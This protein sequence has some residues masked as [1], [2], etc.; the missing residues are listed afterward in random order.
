[1]NC[2]QHLLPAD[3]DQMRNLSF[4]FY[5]LF[6]TNVYQNLFLVLLL[7]AVRSV[8]KSNQRPVKSFTVFV[9]EDTFL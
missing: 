9:R 2:I 1:M 8:L 6:L 3:V 5:F 7:P 4:F